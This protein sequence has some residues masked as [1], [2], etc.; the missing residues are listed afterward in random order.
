M[1]ALREYLY[2]KGKLG[3]DYSHLGFRHGPLV[4][5]CAETYVS[6]GDILVQIR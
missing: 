2:F 4:T 6:V 5:S 1:N 3:R